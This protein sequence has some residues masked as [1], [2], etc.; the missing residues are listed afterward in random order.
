[1]AARGVTERQL[2]LDKTT[3]HKKYEAEFANQT[4]QSDIRHLA[5][6]VWRSAWQL[7]KLEPRFARRSGEKEGAVPSSAKPLTQTG[8]C[9]RGP[10]P[11]DGT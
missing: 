4:W 6:G 1:M 5:I 11:G 7:G 3:A 10:A 8:S 2:L 9:G